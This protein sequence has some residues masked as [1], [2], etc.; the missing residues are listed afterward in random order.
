[1]S[2][3]QLP[4]PA[5]AGLYHVLYID[6][7]WPERGGGKIRRGAN[8]HYDLLTVRKIIE[9]FRVF[10]TWG[11]PDCH[12]YA[13]AT[14]N[15]LP[16]AFECVK[17]AGFRYVTLVTWIKEGRKGLGQYYRGRT[18]HCLFAV[19]GHLPYRIRPDG[20]RAQGETVFYEPCDD[21]IELPEPADLPEA[22][23]A[24]RPR[25]DGKAKHSKKPAQMREYV[26]LVSGTDANLEIFARDAAPGWECWGDEAPAQGDA[27]HA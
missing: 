11:A 14:N 3:I 17:A 8:R 21:A 2:L 9:M 18:E 16:A 12:L 20:K 19:R 24:P 13:W 23:E 4:P 26:E 27:V 5:E 25:V 10:G 6:S 7:P 22:F 1:M 15:Y